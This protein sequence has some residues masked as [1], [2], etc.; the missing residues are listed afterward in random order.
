MATTGFIYLFFQA[1]VVFPALRGW[2]AI[3]SWSLAS[4]RQYAGQRPAEDLK[5]WGCWGHPPPSLHSAAGGKDH[6][7]CVHS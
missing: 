3:C 6:S 4:R 7:G 5:G 1:W 2:W